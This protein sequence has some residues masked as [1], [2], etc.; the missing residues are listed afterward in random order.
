MRESS[1]FEAG[2]DIKI[3]DI[4]GFKVGL[5]IC[6]DCRFPELYRK[7][8]E[9]GCDIVCIPASF[10]KPTGLLH[11]H[12]LC[13]ARAIENQCYILAPNQV[14]IGAQGVE[15]YGHSL[16]IDPEGHILAEASDSN[17]E[18]IVSSIEKDKLNTLRQNFPVLNCR[19]F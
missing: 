11:W 16:I 9:Q 1:A 18:V 7:Y 3:V 14:G 12:T 19:R 17:C 6:F 5:S 8:A 4:D 10:T 13:R 15:T 2:E